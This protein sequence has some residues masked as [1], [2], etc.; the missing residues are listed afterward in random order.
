MMVPLGYVMREP[1]GDLDHDAA[2]GN[3]SSILQF[4]SNAKVFFCLILLVI[5]LLEHVFTSYL[6]LATN[7]CNDNLSLKL[8]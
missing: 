4:S 3:C 2:Y 6:F 5:Y 8:V 1:D 7:F